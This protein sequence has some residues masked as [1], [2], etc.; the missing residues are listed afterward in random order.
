MR[1]KGTSVETEVETVGRGKEV[2]VKRLVVEL[3]EENDQQGTMVG[4]VYG[5]CGGG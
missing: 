1:R 3:E 5:G 4:G 2:E